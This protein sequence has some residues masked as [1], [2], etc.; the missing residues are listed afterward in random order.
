MH[1]LREQIYLY[2]YTYIAYNNNITKIAMPS[3][4]SWDIYMYYMHIK[5]TFTSGCHFPYIG[6]PLVAQGYFCKPGYLA[7][8]GYSICEDSLPCCMVTLFINYLLKYD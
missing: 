4:I 6:P 5:K 2:I 1:Q 7:F 3:L 8:W